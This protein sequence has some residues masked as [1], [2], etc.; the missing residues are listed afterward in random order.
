MIRTAAIIAA[1]SASISFVNTAYANDTA[2]PVKFR[3][4]RSDL[5]TESGRTAIIARMHAFAITKCDPRGDYLVT[6]REAC[7]ANLVDQ[8][9]SAS[10]DDRLVKL[11]EAQD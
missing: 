10:G 5:A 4:D 2:V 6:V 3:I 8:W 9:V 11:A 7:A 1:V